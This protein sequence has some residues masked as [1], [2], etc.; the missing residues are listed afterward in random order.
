V[1]YKEVWFSAFEFTR[2]RK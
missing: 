2:C 1:Y